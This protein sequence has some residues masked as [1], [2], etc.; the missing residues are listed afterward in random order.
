M[1]KGYIECL[2]RLIWTHLNYSFVCVCLPVPDSI[3]C[4]PNGA[5]LSLLFLTSF[6]QR[7]CQ[8]FKSVKASPVPFSQAVEVIEEDSG[9]H[10]DS[11]LQSQ[12]TEAFLSLARFSDAQY[13][14]IDKYM[15]SSEFENKQALLHKAKEEVDLIREN[16]ITDNRSVF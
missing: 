2:C 11:R 12:R 13:Q 4:R 15:N 7:I 8:R 9:V 5:T 16:K 10:R 3:R 6:F 1:N 14:S